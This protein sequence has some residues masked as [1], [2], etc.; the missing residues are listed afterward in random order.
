MIDSLEE[1]RVPAFCP[2]CSG[3]MRGKSTQTFYDWKVCVM[4]FIFFIEGR[5]ERWK[6]G[7]RPT[8]EQVAAA[9]SPE[10]QASD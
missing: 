10:S 6:A 7:W 3:M 2:L 9:H 8:T 5:E 1:L 4:C